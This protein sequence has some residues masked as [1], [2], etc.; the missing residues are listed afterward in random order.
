MA[1][2]Q[3]KK[4]GK[5]EAIKGTMQSWSVRMDNLIIQEIVER[6]ALRKTLEEIKQRQDEFYAVIEK[7]ENRQDM[8]AQLCQIREDLGVVNDRQ[9]N[10]LAGLHSLKK[11]WQLDDNRKGESAEKSE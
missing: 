3:V 10:I 7:I 2:G 9:K 8:L 4:A 6:C 1:H 11:H 5:S